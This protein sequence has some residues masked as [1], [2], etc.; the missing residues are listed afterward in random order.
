MKDYLPIKFTKE[1]KFSFSFLSK[2]TYFAFVGGSGFILKQII[3]YLFSNGILCNW[4]YIE[5]AR[6]NRNVKR[7]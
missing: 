7:E 6:R 5:T 1:N 4:W 2:V 3:C